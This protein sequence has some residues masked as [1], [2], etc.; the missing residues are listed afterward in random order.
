MPFQFG[1]ASLE[2]SGDGDTGTLVTA[3]RLLEDAPN[4]RCGMAGLT[5]DHDQFDLSADP[6]AIGARAVAGTVRADEIDL[7]IVA[8]GSR[9]NAKGVGQFVDANAVRARYAPAPATRGGTD[10]EP[11]LKV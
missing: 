7:L 10:G 2:S 9:R 1:Q 4:L 11:R 6:R 8:Q 3:L 5:Q